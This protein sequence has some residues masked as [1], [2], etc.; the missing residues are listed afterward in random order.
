MNYY[1]WN[2]FSFH[3]LVYEK[4]GTS[5]HALTLYPS[6]LQINGNDSLLLGA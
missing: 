3:K 2:H 5:K 1:I 4:L 6:V